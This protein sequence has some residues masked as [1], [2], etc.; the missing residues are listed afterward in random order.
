MKKIIL[1]F[2][3]IIFSN[4]R[5]WSQEAERK[6]NE[7]GIKIKS[8]SILNEE[9]KALLLINNY[10]EYREYES[11]AI[12]KIKRGPELELFSIKE[13]QDKGKEYNQDFIKAKQDISKNKYPAKAI[14]LV[15]IGYNLT[16][17]KQPK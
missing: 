3:V 13:M 11:R 15:D 5:S 7:A 8:E 14:P 17:V 6:L 16:E 4:Y 2:C 10:D 9:N 1:I 12:V